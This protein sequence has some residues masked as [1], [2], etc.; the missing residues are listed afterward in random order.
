MLYVN[1]IFL[2]VRYNAQHWTE[3]K[4]NWRASVCLVSV[5]KTGTSILKRSSPNL[6]HSFPLTSQRK[7]LLGRP[8]TGRGQ[9]HVTGFTILHSLIISVS[10]NDTAFKFY[11]Q[12]KREEHNK[13]YTQDTESSP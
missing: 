7:Y 3:Y 11:T 2:S 9:G 4:I 13:I 6:K 5:D 8:L 12:L 10:L 1:F